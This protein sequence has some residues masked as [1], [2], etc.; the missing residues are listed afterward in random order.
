MKTKRISSKLFKIEEEQT[1][2][3]PNFRIKEE[4][5]RTIP[6]LFKIKEKR[7]ELVQKILRSKKSLLGRF[8]TRRPKR[9]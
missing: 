9:V 1:D 5:N 2:V 3:V 8:S 7:R 4:T 6:K